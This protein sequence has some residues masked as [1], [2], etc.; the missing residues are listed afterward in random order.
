M[1]PADCVVSVSRLTN[2]S[3]SA[4]CLEL[5]VFQQFAG[6]ELKSCTVLCIT[7]WLAR[8]RPSA[9][10]AM[11]RRERPPA[12]PRQLRRSRSRRRQP[13]RR[14]RAADALQCPGMMRNAA[15]CELQRFRS[16]STC[17]GA[18]RAMA[19]ELLP[20]GVW[21]ERR[22]VRSARA[23]QRPARAT[24]PLTANF[25]L[26]SVLRGGR[27]LC[28]RPRSNPLSFRGWDCC[29]SFRVSGI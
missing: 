14:L 23:C 19:K 25:G 18:M 10:S 17:R 13:R 29:A 27:R 2:R 1:H 11:C 21:R 9:T 28:G 24:I 4:V 12:S 5:A 3:W 15:A 20:P 6:P 8:W 16:A 22:A 7:R 26:V